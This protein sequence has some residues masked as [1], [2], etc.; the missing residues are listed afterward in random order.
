MIALQLNPPIFCVTPKGDG[1]ARVVFDYGP[2]ANPV[3]LVE[4][5]AS[6]EWL[7]F[8]MLDMRGSGNSMWNLSHPEPPESRA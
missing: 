5:N 6:R 1:I 2:D 8:D 4:L 3:F 7:C